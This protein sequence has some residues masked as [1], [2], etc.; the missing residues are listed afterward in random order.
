MREFFKTSWTTKQDTNGLDHYT[1]QQ[2]KILMQKIRGTVFEM[3]SGV[4]D[5]HCCLFQT[6]GYYCFD[7]MNPNLWHR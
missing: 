4:R 3:Q 5:K 1:A 7:G 6:M 2:F